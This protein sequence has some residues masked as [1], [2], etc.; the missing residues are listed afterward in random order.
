M[1]RMA[2]EIVINK[3]AFF[4]RLSHFCAAWKSD[5]RAGDATFGGVGSIVILAGKAEEAGSYQ[6]N[7]ALH[8]SFD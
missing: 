6:K 2:D 4:D 1:N 8:V 7:N 3:Q 5:K